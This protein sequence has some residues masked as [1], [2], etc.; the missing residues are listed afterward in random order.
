MTERKFFKRVVTIEVL[1]ES[2]IPEGMS[3]T[4]MIIEAMSGDYSMRAYNV[5]DKELNGKQAAKALLNQGSDPSFFGL[6]AR[7]NDTTD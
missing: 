4:N 3:I 7:G 2:P 6:S 1:S 5:N